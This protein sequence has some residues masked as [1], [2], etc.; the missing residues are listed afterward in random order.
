VSL[1]GKYFTKP[2]RLRLIMGVC[3][4]Y[5]ASTLSQIYKLAV[6]Q[7]NRA[8]STEQEPISLID[9]SAIPNLVKLKTLKL[10]FYSH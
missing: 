6:G 10:I 7:E 1:K 9:L 4:L 8:F 3:F 2:I 5:R